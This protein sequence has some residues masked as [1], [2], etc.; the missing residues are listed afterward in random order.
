[1]FYLTKTPNWVS[2]L[3]TGSV[4]ELPQ[5][6]K[7]VYLSFDDGP[8]PT[9]T[10]F[11]LN[12]LRKYDAKA[13]FFC[14]G[15]NVVK[16]KELFNR[17]LAEGHAVGNHTFD[18][19]NG[20]K[21]SQKD[22]LDNILK[23]NEYIHSNLFRPPYGKITTSQHKLL[24]QHNEPF[25]II[26]WSVLSGDF[27]I[28]ISKQKCCDNVINNCKNGSIIVFHDSEKAKERMEYTLPLVLHKLDQDGYL[29]KKIEF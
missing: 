12:E 9:I 20:W 28:N 11:V 16:E 19:L 4:W 17:I 8:H 2:K 1:M 23:A 5:M 3:F 21:T 24:S 15:K 13:T 18:H 6:Q 26:M 25:K 14:V 22:Y 10:P 27:D 7:T 29:M